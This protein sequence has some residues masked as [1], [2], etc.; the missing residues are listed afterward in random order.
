LQSR[1]LSPGT[2]IFSVNSLCAS[3]EAGTLAG[4][5]VFQCVPND[6][7]CSSESRIVA[8]EHLLHRSV[9]ALGDT[10]RL[11]QMFSCW[12][13]ARCRTL[14]VLACSGRFHERVRCTLQT[15]AN[16]VPMDHG[17]VERSPI[18]TETRIERKIRALDKVKQ[19]RILYASPTGRNRCDDESPSRSPSFMQSEEMRASHGLRCASYHGVVKRRFAYARNESRIGLSHGS[20]FVA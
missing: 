14:P 9:H 10:R 16:A 18:H 2:R 7:S 20:G 4:S 17:F 12:F 13:R 6:A 3:L 1:S 11:S 8:C 5:Q 15:Q 19:T